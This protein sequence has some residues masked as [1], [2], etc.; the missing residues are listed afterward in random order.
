[1]GK[2]IVVVGNGGYGTRERPSD[3][4][5]TL[6][7]DL[8]EF[9]DSADEVIRFQ[10]CTNY[11]SKMLGTKTTGLVTRDLF[12]PHVSA[13]YSPHGH[14]YIPKEVVEQLSHKQRIVRPTMLYEVIIDHQ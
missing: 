12:S 14:L 7:K 1:M 6:T 4:E 9:V 8:S 13:L 5:C 11:E 10:T 3:R 2:K